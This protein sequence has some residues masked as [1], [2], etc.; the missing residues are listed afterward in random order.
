MAYIKSRKHAVSRA[1]QQS[2]TATAVA[3]AA[4]AAG[5]ALAQASGGTLG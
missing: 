3:L 4:L 5:P 1:P 2:I